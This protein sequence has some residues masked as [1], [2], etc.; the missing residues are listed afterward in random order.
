[1]IYILLCAYNEEESIE[2]LLRSI[3]EV[4]KKNEHYYKIIVVDDG[5]SDQTASLTE[6]YSQTMPVELLKNPVNLGL[7]ASLKNGFE[8]LVKIISDKDL[9]ITLDSDNTHDPR[10]F[11][12]LIEKAGEG[13]DIVIAS[14]FASGGQEIGLSLFRKILSRGAYIYLKLLFN[15][16]GVKDYTCGYRIYSADIIKKG[17]EKYGSKLIE[18]SGFV[19]MAELLIKLSN[20]TSKIAETGLV[21]RYDQKMTPSKMKLFNTISGY[22]KLLKY[23]I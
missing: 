1:M 8:Y 15:I 13:F 2:K 10:L 16:P 19:C 5:S 12:K 23:K 6:K 20:L 4:F 9:I 7:G 18:N 21:L 22:F 17:F 11:A 14:R 3:K